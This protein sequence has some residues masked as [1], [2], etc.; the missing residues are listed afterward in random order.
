MI[1]LSP[2]VFYWL[3]SQNLSVED[4]RIGLKKREGR[5]KTMKGNEWK[6]ENPF[7]LSKV[8]SS[9][10]FLSFPCPSKGSLLCN[11]LGIHYG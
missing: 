10:S 5:I 4:R 6:M 2:I 1:A 8:P 11:F 9:R 7:G 3:S